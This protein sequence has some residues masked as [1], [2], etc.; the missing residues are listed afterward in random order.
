MSGG[1][2]PGAIAL[3]TDGR[4]VFTGAD[5]LYA[6]D[7]NGIQLW[8]YDAGSNISSAP[9]IKNNRV[10]VAAGDRV[11]CV[12][13][14]GVAIWTSN[15]VS[16]GEIKSGVNVT[17]GRVF[18]GAEDGIVYAI[19]ESDGSDVWK[20]TT[21]GAVNSS[22]MVY[23]GMVIV[24]SD[25]NFIYNLDVLPDGSGNGQLRWKVGTGERVRSSAAVHEFSNTVYIGCHDYN[26]YALNHV[27]GDTRYEYAAGS[28]VNT[29][30]IVTDE[31]AYFASY[32]KYFYCIRVSDG[33]TVWK[34]NLDNI[35]V[36]SPVLDLVNEV[37]YS[38]I[39]G[40]SLR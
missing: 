22:P 3:A 35:C 2:D 6:Y 34:S 23:G 11:H 14:A 9:T 27:T 10:Y 25:D 12:D 17:D 38:G 37:H 24:G 13:T 1:G 7:L 31:Y 28:L 19:N 39:S 15:A 32:D 26:V 5:R 33:V 29:S 4:H 18:Y 16:G 8:S 36:S 40:M 21:A 30:P 20:Y